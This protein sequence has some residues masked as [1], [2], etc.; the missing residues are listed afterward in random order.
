MCAALI[1]MTSMTFILPFRP[2]A[3]VPTLKTMLLVFQ[4]LKEGRVDGA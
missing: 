4:K 1:M 3:V 2:M